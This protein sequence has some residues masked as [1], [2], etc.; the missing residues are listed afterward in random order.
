MMRKGREK[1][2][3]KD[4]VL[5]QQCLSLFIVRMFQ[6]IQL[7][8]F[9][10]VQLTVSSSTKYRIISTDITIEA[11]STRVVEATSYAGI[12]Y[13]KEDGVQDLVTFTSAKKLNALL[14]VHL[15]FVIIYSY[16]YYYYYYL[17]FNV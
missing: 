11:L 16:Y 1:M 12:L 17:L 3:L 9:L 10:M 4:Q 14:E 5:Q 7:K 15:Y 13:Y 6:L 8:I 2:I